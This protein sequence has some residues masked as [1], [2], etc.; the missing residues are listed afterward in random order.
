MSLVAVIALKNTPEPL[1]VLT[2]VH[3]LIVPL[4]ASMSLLNPLGG[5]TDSS[6]AV[7]NKENILN[8]VFANWVI[9]FAIFKD[10]ILFVI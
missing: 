8:P 3:K 2:L 5:V 1:I 7:N 10:I 4:V 9:L 6:V